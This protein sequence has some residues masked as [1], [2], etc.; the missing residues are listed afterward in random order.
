MMDFSSAKLIRL[1]DKSVPLP[2][3]LRESGDDGDVAVSTRLRIARNMDGCR[4]PWCATDFELEQVVQLM[5]D[6][7]VRMGNLYGGGALLEADSLSDEERMDMVAWRYVSRD[8][9]L[10]AKRRALLILGDGVTSVMVNEEDHL[11]IQA[12]LPGLQVKSVQKHA[13]NAE[14]E[15]AKHIRFAWSPTF[16][17]LTSSLSNVGLGVR[18][19]VLLHLPGLRYMERIREVLDAAAL[20]GC[21]VRGTYGEGTSE[22]GDFHLVSNSNRMGADWG[23]ITGRFV[24]A[25]DFVINEERAARGLLFGGEKGRVRLEDTCH[26]AY[27][28]LFDEEPK[29]TDLLSIIS[30]LRLA[31]AEGALPGRIEQTAPW[32][33]MTGAEW[34]RGDAD[35][36]RERYQIIRRTAMLRQSLRGF[37]SSVGTL[38]PSVAN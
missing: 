22:M 12:I 37:I 19:G 15:I 35:K 9:A 7:S 33:A 26:Q 38:R 30:A 20:V 36:G 11:R 17:Y 6:V 5:H 31:V 13:Q 16:G 34:V 14:E 27:R 28:Y 25:I 1:S 3:W 2:V 18:F 10:S 21:S 24:S 4:F 29:L 23:E 8:W 32:I